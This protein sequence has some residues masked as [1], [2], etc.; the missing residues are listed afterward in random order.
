MHNVFRFNLMNLT[1]SSLFQ[2]LL[3]EVEAVEDENVDVLVTDH[4]EG[5][6]DAEVARIENESTAVPDS[7]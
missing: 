4:P 6:V 2:T 3:K 1:L 5:A 7:S